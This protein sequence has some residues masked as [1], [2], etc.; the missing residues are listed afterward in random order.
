MSDYWERIIRQRPSR[1]RLLAGAG[2]AGAGIAAIS[3][4]GCG[5]GSTARLSSGQDEGGVIS[6]PVDTTKEA[7]PGGVIQTRATLDVPGFDVLQA[8]STNTYTLVGDFAYS[9]LL[10]MKPGHMEPAR[11]EPEGDL[12]QS[13]E[14]LDGGLTLVVKLK[15]EAKWDPRPPT[16]GRAV[17][18]RD[19]VFSWNKYETVGR[20]RARL[21]NKANPDA[22][23]MSATAI[24]ERTVQ[25]RLAFPFAILE[26]LLASNED[27]YIQPQE[28]DGGFDP[29]STV[30]G[31]GAY[32][33][34]NYQQSL[35]LSY[36]KNPNWYRKDLPFVDGYDIYILPEYAAA[37]SQFRAGTIFTSVVRQE[38]VVQTKKDIPELLLRL[39][40]SLST[41]WRRAHFGWNHPDNKM[42]LDERVRR[43]MSMSWDR[44]S[45][46]RIFGNADQFEAEGLP[47]SNRW[48]SHITGGWDGW[49]IDPKD[50]KEFGSA[51]KWF[52]HDIAEAKKLLAAAGH[53]NGIDSELSYISGAFYGTDWQNRWEVLSGMMR[54]AGIRLRTNITDYNTEHLP[55]YSIGNLFKGISASIASPT[56]HPIA[57][58]TQEFA[59]VGAPVGRGAGGQ[60]EPGY[61]EGQPLSGIDPKL[62][63]MA[64]RLRR[65]LDHKKQVEQVK[66]YQRYLG[67]KMYD[68]PMPGYSYTYS[69]TWPFVMN[70][71]VYRT[72]VATAS[73]P[74]EGSL[75]LWLDRT[76]PKFKQL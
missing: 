17:T 23:V 52:Q 20:T 9:R 61:V 74:Q 55:I 34:T 68:I 29:K 49:W 15:P 19:V 70:L 27:L 72:W 4:A 63:E 65:E 58:L 64:A 30:R 45:F 36:R 5:G 39:S 18:A 48:S 24:D 6:K 76:H 47:F 2:A 66:D 10:K 57:H 26:P 54:E 51:S 38:D 32:M 22:P 1:R 73:G 69:L 56:S 31:S 71:G 35:S 62:N 33:V 28:A 41:I 14:L 59:R 44:D 25:F 3:L 11:G 50:P 67:D 8:T 60:P 7:K 75:Y 46:D 42:F 37:V 21:A 53:P 13:W 43:A 12:A 16:N 40:E